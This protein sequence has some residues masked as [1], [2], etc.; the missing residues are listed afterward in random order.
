VAESTARTLT[1]LHP[2]A[3]ELRLA[4]SELEVPAM[5]QARIVVYVPRDDDTRARMPLTRRTVT[6]V[7]VVG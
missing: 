6:P 4:V 2:H 3:G 7:Q 5:P 1:Y